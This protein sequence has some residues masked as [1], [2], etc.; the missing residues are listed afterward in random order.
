MGLVNTERGGNSVAATL[1]AIRWSHLTVQ[2]YA[3]RCTDDRPLTGYSH[4]HFGVWEGY[5]FLPEALFLYSLTC[6]LFPLR[7]ASWLS[8][9]CYNELLA[10]LLLQSK[11][12]GEIQLIQPFSRE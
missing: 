3:G 8:P 12:R 1:F 4:C 2:L 6:I 5:Q 11:G 7:S 10:N 9:H